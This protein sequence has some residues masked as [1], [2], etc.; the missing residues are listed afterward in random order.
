[1]G[2][3]VS[4]V[5]MLEKTG[6]ERWGSEPAYRH[7]MENTPC[8]IPRL[9]APPPFKAAEFRSW[10]AALALEVL[11]ELVS[12]VVVASLIF[13]SKRFG[14]VQGMP[15]EANFRVTECPSKAR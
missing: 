11:R 9:T 2:N 4:G 7:Y 12:Q 14:A 15:F 10:T 1:M 8:V 6:E 5:P 3:Y 13:A